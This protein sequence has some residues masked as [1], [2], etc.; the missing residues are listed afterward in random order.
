MS[1]FHRHD[2]FFVLVWLSGDALQVAVIDTKKDD[3]SRIVA[4]TSYKIQVH[5]ETDEKKVLSILGATLDKALLDLE[6]KTRAQNPH[7]RI[8]S[9]HCFLSSPW[10]IS[11]T[12]N[13]TYNAPKPAKVTPAF[14]DSLVEADTTA[15]KE[16]LYT[17]PYG[18]IF[19]KS[20]DVIEN[21]ILTL[22]YNGYEIAD[23]PAAAH[24]QSVSATIYA[25]VAGHELTEKIEGSLHK[26]F[27]IRSIQWHTVPVSLY[28]ILRKL[29]PAAHDYMLIDVGNIVTDIGIVK[30]GILSETMTIPFG[31]SHCLDE[32]K[33]SLK[34]NEEAALSMCRLEQQGG[35]Q[36]ESALKLEAA[37]FKN[38]QKWK[39][40]FDAAQKQMSEHFFLPTAVFIRAEEPFLTFWEMMVKEGDC[41]HFGSI[42]CQCVPTKLDTSF[43]KTINV[44][45]TADAATIYMLAHFLDTT[46]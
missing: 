4:R 21:K 31:F 3:I 37:R 11:Q 16:A 1:L 33:K 25:S 43:L 19:N 42:H 34:V 6:K 7:I 46:I 24:A 17:G 13:I 32:V 23:I 8:H 26:H 14:I 20:L 22:T 28:A 5:N 27:A 9:A 18:R 12:R 10:F 29:D 39:E 45:S 38:Q 36:P 40:Y 35:L 30:K 15:F 44:A 2:D 41:I